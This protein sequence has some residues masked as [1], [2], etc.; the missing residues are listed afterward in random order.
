MRVLVVAGMEPFGV[1]GARCLLGTIALAPLAVL[2]RGRFPR[3][4]KTW[5]W[6]VALGLFNFAIPWTLFSLGQKHVPS[7]IGSIA[8]SALPLSAAVI[9]TIM[10]K[11]ERLGPTRIVGLLLGFAGVLVVVS[12]RVDG[13]DEESL[14]GIPPMLLATLFYGVCIVSIRKYLSHVPALP[15]TFAQIG[16][17]ALALMPL[18]LATG[19]FS[20]VSM[21]WQEWTS[22]LVLGVAGSGLT[23][24]LYMWLIGEV[25]PVRAGVATYLMPPV[26][27]LLGRVFLGEAVG[28]SMIVWPRSWS[29]PPTSKRAATWALCTCSKRISQMR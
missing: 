21:G 17:A 18:A 29:S 23:P 28:W 24:V 22:L 10:I 2:L 5:T 7:G 12:G 26:G 25:G 1:S 6:L 20:D 27:L 8:N 11:T 3:D 19:S 4:R 14:L 16:V 13:L 15:L 9:S